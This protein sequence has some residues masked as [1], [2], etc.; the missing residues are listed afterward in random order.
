MERCE[1]RPGIKDRDT[2]GT[3]PIFG[4]EV[5]GESDGVVASAR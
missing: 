1:R 2:A 3:C 5:V 4:L